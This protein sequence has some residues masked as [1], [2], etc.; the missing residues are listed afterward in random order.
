MQA[1]VAEFR[2]RFAMAR[3]HRNGAKVAAGLCLT[4]P[5]QF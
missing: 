4:I 5:L 1:Q 2:R 3:P